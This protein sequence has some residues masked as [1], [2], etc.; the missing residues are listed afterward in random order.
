[1]SKLTKLCSILLLCCF[2]TLFFQTNNSFAAEKRFSIGTAGIS[3]VLYPFGVSLAQTITKHTDMQATGE[4]SAGSI[5][6]IRNLTTGKTAIAFSQNQN[7]TQAYQGTH[8]YKNKSAPD[9]RSIMATLVS[10]MHIFVPKDSA[11]NTIEDLKGL[12]V[13]VGAA[14]SG[15]EVDTRM[16]LEFHNLNYQTIKPQFIPESEA[17]SALK[18]GRIDAIIATH[19]LNSTAMTELTQ[20][21][22]LKLI[23]VA[24]DAFY[25]TYP[26][27]AKGIIEAG[28]YPHIDTDVYSPRIISALFTSTKSGLTDDE[29]YQITKAIWENENEWI[30]V[31]ASVSKNVSLKN[32]LSGLIIPLSKGALRYYEE[33]GVEIPEHLKK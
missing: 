4:A 20:S 26:Y 14:G 8:V 5:E 24:N 30:N 29:V 1:M 9:L 16:L 23:P 25:T 13:S 28:T 3:G 27:F 7:A 15:G 31:H 21:M 2:T 17:I 12:R 19:P 10:Y 6:N 22:E 32:A 33:I 11:V 18:D